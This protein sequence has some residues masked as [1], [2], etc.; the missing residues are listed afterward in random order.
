MEFIKQSESFTMK[1]TNGSLV[2]TGTVNREISGSLNMHF[3]VTRETGE[4][5]GEGHY[6]KYGVSG[7][8]NLGVN[9]SE[10]HR[11]ELTA[12]ADTVVDSVLEYFKSLK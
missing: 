1:D 6:S 10:E 7:D 2:L 8:I 12:Y 3:S 11:D 4:R 5:V 9:C